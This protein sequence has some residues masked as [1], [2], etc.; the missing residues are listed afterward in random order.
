MIPLVTND[1]VFLILNNHH[2]VIGRLGYEQD[3]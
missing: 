1:N 3:N 2:S